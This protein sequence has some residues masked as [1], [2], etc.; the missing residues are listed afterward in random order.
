MITRWQVTGRNQAEKVGDM[1]H[2]LL[3]IITLSKTVESFASN[4]SSRWKP[5]VSMAIT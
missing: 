5:I 1:N 2:Y 3:E 4:F